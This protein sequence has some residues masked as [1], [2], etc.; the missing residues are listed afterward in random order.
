M[1]TSEESR[2]EEQDG[3]A[4]RSGP[5][6]ESAPSEKQ[7]AILETAAALF[8]EK[9]YKATSIRDIG[10]RVGILG[11]SLY[12]YIKSKDELFVEVHNA[13][14]DEAQDKIL[15]AVSVQTDPWDRLHAAVKALVNLQLDPSS[16]TMPITNDFRSVPKELR[17]RLLL[18]RDKFESTFADL[19]AA[20]PMD[21]QF[22]RSIFRL[23]LLT[24]INNAATWYRGGR[25]SPS[26]VADQIMMIFRH[27]K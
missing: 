17:A 6:A 22:D 14:L 8:A 18:R 3:F 1:T 11:G 7:I 24:L 5:G 23:S 20:L 15:E 13:A 16:I 12:H 27:D 21:P 19:I 9:G 2:S 4:K 25:L 26:D 10:N